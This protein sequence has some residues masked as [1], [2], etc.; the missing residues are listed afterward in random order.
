MDIKTAP[1]RVKAGE[2]DGLAEGEILLYPA[3]FI[4]QADSYGD[5]IAPGAFLDDIAAWKASGNVLPGLF[6]HR[7]DDP[8]MFIA[9]TLDEGEDDHGWWVKGAFD[10][11]NPVAQQVY[12]LAKG[13]RLNQVSFAYDVLE[14][15]AVTLE[16]GS[17]ANE[18]RKVKRY[19]WS[20]VPVGAN[21]DTSIVAVKALVDSIKAGR[22]ISAKNEQSLREA[23]DS[24]DSVLASLGDDDAAK[25][26]PMGGTPDEASGHTDAKDE[27]PAG[28]KSEEPRVTPSART[29]AELDLIA[30]NGQEGA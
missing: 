11:D 13:R 14:S 24:I 2:A 19:E 28:A 25:S 30:L 27:E 5:V 22:T 1:C 20:I 16:D 10:L 21:Q 6:G 26:T 9:E 7:M 4:R 29:L 8:M 12:K 17:K 15:G 18:L 23:R 3:T